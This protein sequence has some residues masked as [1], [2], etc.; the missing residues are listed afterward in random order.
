MGKNLWSGF[1]C[2]NFGS[3]V[4]PKK[5]MK[6]LFSNKQLALPDLQTNIYYSAFDLWNRYAYYAFIVRNYL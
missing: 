4:R 2:R 6:F 3:A 5:K 1:V